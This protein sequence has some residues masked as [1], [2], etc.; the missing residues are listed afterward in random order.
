[1]NQKKSQERNS[2]RGKLVGSCSGTSLTHLHGEHFLVITCKRGL[3]FFS[4][5]FGWQSTLRLKADGGGLKKKTNDDSLPWQ[6]KQFLMDRGWCGLKQLY[7]KAHLVLSKPISWLRPSRLFY[8]YTGG[9]FCHSISMRQNQFVEITT[10]SCLGWLQNADLEQA[11][12]DLF[13]SILQWKVACFHPEWKMISSYL[14][15]LQVPLL[16]FKQVGHWTM[17][18][19]PLVIAGEK[20]G[21]EFVPTWNATVMSTIICMQV[22]SLT[23]NKSRTDNLLPCLLWVNFRVRLHWRL[24]YLCISFL[25]LCKKWVE[26][27]PDTRTM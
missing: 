22:D 24:F 10:F 9:T 7:E 8:Y 5:F 14:M 4:F 19:G 18:A 1:M 2:K 26:R 27:T 20:N 11:R 21:A 25:I 23:D 13:L 16:T 3:S 17:H 15:V 12:G 6:R